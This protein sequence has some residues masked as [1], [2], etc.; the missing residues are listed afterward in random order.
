[1]IFYFLHLLLNF[2]LFLKIKL[3]NNSL[4]LVSQ[5]FD[6]L[7]VNHNQKIIQDYIQS[8]YTSAINYKMDFKLLNVPIFSLTNMLNIT[9]VQEYINISQIVIME[10][11]P[12]NLVFLTK[13]IFSNF[14]NGNDPFNISDFELDKLLFAKRKRN[15][16]GLKHCFKS[17]R[18][19]IN[20]QFKDSQHKTCP[21]NDMFPKKKNLQKLYKKNSITK[22]SVIPLK[23]NVNFKK[24]SE[25]F[26]HSSFICEEIYK[27]IISKDSEIISE[28]LTFSNFVKILFDKQKKHSWILQN[29]L[30]S[31]EMYNF[32]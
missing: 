31:L 28:S 19:G 25:N 16:E 22:K 20:K 8:K 9:L 13:Q 11:R 6:P 30:N 23:N 29:I 7:I 24:R 27:Q 21:L 26:K 15:D 14:S 1:M 32:C 17:I 10:N 5:Y 3:E 12:S 2:E 18:R 4:D